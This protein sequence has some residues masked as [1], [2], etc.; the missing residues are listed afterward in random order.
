MKKLNLLYLLLGLFNILSVYSQEIEI[1]DEKFHDD[2]VCR[3]SFRVRVI[4][5]ASSPNGLVRITVYP[6]S[7]ESHSEPAFPLYNEVFGDMQVIN[8]L[9]DGSRV[10]ESKAITMNV[11]DSYVNVDVELFRR[12]RRKNIWGK[13]TRVLKCNLDTFKRYTMISRGSDLEEARK[14]QCL[15]SNGGIVDWNLQLP[16]TLYE[17]KI[18]SFTRGSSVYFYEIKNV[19]PASYNATRSDINLEVSGPFSR[20]CTGVVDGDGNVDD[21][22]DT[23]NYDLELKESDVFVYSSCGSCVSQLNILN[24]GFLGGTFPVRKHLM[25]TQGNTVQTQFLIKNNGSTYSKD[26]KIRF[27]L[28]KGYNSV[29]GVQANDKVLDLGSLPPGGEFLS[30]PTF[31]LS[32]F[33]VA[34]GYYYLVIDIE[35]DEGESNIKNNFISIPV[36]VKSISGRRTMRLRSNEKSYKIEV[37]NFNGTKYSDHIIETIN[38]E[39]VILNNL[40]KGLYIIKK[41]KEFY[42]ISK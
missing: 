34:I 4:N 2:G 37:F 28:S 32:D 36:E 1:F 13:S 39:K 24:P 23:S 16:I 9:S 20:D 7:Q 33:K 22:T 18:Y 21:N 29:F 41:D 31:K 11:G 14:H 30:N 15:G 42:K 26:V 25:T 6:K 3:K 27:Y 12:K 35:S 5:Y 17:G 8:T 40:K 19:F 10:Y 38:D